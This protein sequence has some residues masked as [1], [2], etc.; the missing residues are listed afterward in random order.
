MQNTTFLF[1]FS[2]GTNSK[3][4]KH[5]LLRNTRAQLAS[6]AIDGAD[7][8]PSLCT[9]SDPEDHVSSGTLHLTF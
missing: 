7:K 1:L 3:Q 2:E 5:L 6:S 4:E 8:S 9:I